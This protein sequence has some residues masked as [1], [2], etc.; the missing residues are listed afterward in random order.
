VWVPESNMTSAFINQLTNIGQHNL[1]RHNKKPSLIDRRNR[2]VSAMMKTATT[3]FYIAS[4]PL[5]ATVIEPGIGLQARYL[6]GPGAKEGHTFHYWRRKSITR[7]YTRNRNL[8]A[9]I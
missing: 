5:L 1:S 2:A 7:A 6:S 9:C 3:G 8:R 4:Q